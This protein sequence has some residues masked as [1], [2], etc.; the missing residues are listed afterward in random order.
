LRSGW[1]L[2]AVAKALGMHYRSVQRWAAWYRAGG[3]A[4]VRAH[5][6]G[7]RGQVAF[8]SAEAEAELAAVATGRF[9]TGAAIA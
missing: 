3:L 6:M 5:R 4:G 9:R 8:L 7:G 2:G 1:A